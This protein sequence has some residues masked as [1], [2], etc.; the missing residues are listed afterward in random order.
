MH[1]ARGMVRVSRGESTHDLAIALEPALRGA[2]DDRLG[3]IDWFVTSH[4]RG[5]AATGAA[6]WTFDDQHAADVI[7]KLPV[8][9]VEY[10]WNIDL[11]GAREAHDWSARG[12]DRPPIPRVVAGSRVLGGYD[13]AWVVVERLGASLDPAALAKPI[14][15]RALD[16]VARFHAEALRTRPVSGRPKDYPWE[17]MIERSRE[18]VRDRLLNL[19][20]LH[21]WN[22]GL[23]RISKMAPTL[24]R[25]WRSRP[26]DTWCHGDVHPANI[27]R[28]SDADDDLVLIDLGL[29]HPGCWIEDALYLERQFWAHPEALHGVK[30]LQALGRARRTRGLDNG[31]EYAELAHIQRL[32]L[33]GCVPARYVDEGTPAYAAA[34]LERA[35]RLAT[36]LG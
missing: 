17:Q 2:C 15:E 8:G 9:P 36:Q 16:T 34:A 28:C 11:G 30:P 18:L 12:D 33:A 4:Q 3:P 13:L 10:A 31:E 35:E 27:M 7:I 32:L 25:R 20:E 22:E 29:V 14:V 1:L 21:R 5:G 24:I 6:R 23:K 26:I 19:D